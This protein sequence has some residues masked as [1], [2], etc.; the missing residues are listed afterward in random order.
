MNESYFM[1]LRPVGAELFYT[2]TQTN[3][4]KQT[5]AFRNVVKSLKHQVFL[6]RGHTAGGTVG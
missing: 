3:M 2:N 1:K 4:A 5:L 6:S